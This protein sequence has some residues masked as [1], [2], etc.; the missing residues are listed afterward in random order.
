FLGAADEAYAA[1]RASTTDVA[2]IA[3]H[4]GLKP[5]NIQTVKNHV[6]EEVHLLDRYVDYGEPAVW[7]RFDSDIGQ[8]NAWQ[9]LQSGTHTPDDIAWLKHEMAEG[10][11]M[12]QHGP[13]YSAAHDA[14]QH[15]YPAPD[16]GE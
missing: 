3:R 2:D 5:E 12:R 13:G 1:I 8:A 4:T 10:W 6:F 16:F 9:R 15:R 7:A 11:Y 14:A